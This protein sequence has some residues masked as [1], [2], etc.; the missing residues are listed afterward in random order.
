ME[1]VSGYMEI[2]QTVIWPAVS[3]VG[4]WFSPRTC[5]LADGRLVMTC[6]RINAEDGYEGVHIAWSEDRGRNW[7]EPVPVTSLQRSVFNA[8]VEGEWEEAVCDVVPSELADGRLLLI[9]Q[10]V[11]YCNGVLASAN[12]NRKTIY[13][14]L[15][16]DG[17]WSERRFLKWDDKRC[18]RSLYAGCAQRVTLEDGSIL[19]PV[20]HTNSDGGR[21]VAVLQLSVT[22][23]EIVVLD[24]SNSLN[25]EA[26]RGLLEPSLIESGGKYW[27]TIRAEDGRGYWS[28]SDNGLNW[29]EITNWEF[30]DG[31]PLVTDTTQQRWVVT[32]GGLHLIYTR[33]S[34]INERVFRWRAPLWIARVEEGVLLRESEMRVLPAKGERLLQIGNFHAITLTD[35]SGLV[36]VSETDIEQSFAGRTLMARLN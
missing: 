14:F 35:G 26:G 13:T 12:E 28:I 27:M 1:G 24:N 9:G 33:R 36:T 5:Q 10:N 18:A 15:D 22:A 34:A 20:S 30:D 19:L 21:G 2:E 11:Y 29:S 3:D 7:S 16:R 23:E 6:Q 32:K 17:F 25:L 4:A 31:M 8:G